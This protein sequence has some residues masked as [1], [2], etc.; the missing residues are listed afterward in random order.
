[1]SWRFFREKG[2]SLIGFIRDV[3]Q[4]IFRED[5]VDFK[6][7]PLVGDRSIAVGTRG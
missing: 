2:M 7:P 3:L 6:Q 5:S 1:M 4:I